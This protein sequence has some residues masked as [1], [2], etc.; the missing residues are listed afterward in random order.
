M[1]GVACFKNAF[2]EGEVVALLREFLGKWH[3]DDFSG[4]PEHCR[5][6]GIRGSRDIAEMAFNL[7]TTRIDATWPPQMLVELDTLF[8]HACHRL[9]EIQT[10]AAHAPPDASP[11]L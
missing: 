2:S 10:I 6:E 3:R 4:L 1:T 7:T 9:T 5:P 11:T 8:A